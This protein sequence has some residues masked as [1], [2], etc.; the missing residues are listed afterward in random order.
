V[1][2]RLTPAGALRDSRWFI[3]ALAMILGLWV[4]YGVYRIHQPG[5]Q[6]DEALF[7]PAATDGG[8]GSGGNQFVSKRAFGWPVL[9][10]PYIGALKSWLFTPWFDGFGVSVIT[11]RLPMLLLFAAGVALLCVALRRW[12]GDFIALL[13]ACLLVTDP[14]FASMIRGDQGPVGLSAVLRV[15]VLVLIMRAVSSRQAGWLL[16]AVLAIGLGTFNKLDFVIFAGPVLLATPFLAGYACLRTW[17]RQRVALAA[18]GAMLLMVALAA[19][20]FM[21][22][23]SSGFAGAAGSLSERF[24]ARWALLVDTFEA[25]GVFRY[26]TGEQPSLRVPVLVVSLGLAAAAGATIIGF[27][28][29]ARPSRVRAP[30]EPREAERQGALRPVVRL[31]LFTLVLVF[32]QF[33]A[34]VSTGQVAGPHHALLMWP[35]PQLLTAVSVAVLL[36]AGLAGFLRTAVRSAVAVVMA[37]LIALQLSLWVWVDGAWADPLRRAVVWTQEIEGVARCLATPSVGE[38][39]VVVSDWGLGNQLMVLRGSGQSRVSD[40]WGAYTAVANADA[41][42]EQLR[43]RLATEGHAYFVRH[44]PGRDVFPVTTATSSTVIRN[45][46]RSGTTVTRMW[47]GRDLEVWRLGASQRAPLARLR[48]R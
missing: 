45:L 33:V 9:L 23:P 3:P 12:V 11:I 6:Y 10:M 21:Y 26:M 48:C 25:G 18:S 37:L 32:G 43:A 39:L 47:T 31:W 19:Y 29:A 34:M 13:L 30:R 40:D 20:R 1:R 7:V 8:H 38:S 5:L 27:M 4:L 44:R 17:A 28:S 46:G 14:V 15:L 35:A 22:V 2:D 16:L 41:L 42:T 36:H 24:S